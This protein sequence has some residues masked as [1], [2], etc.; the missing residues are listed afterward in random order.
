MLF[1]SQPLKQ[2]TPMKRSPWNRKLSE[3]KGPGLAQRIAQSLGN[4]IHHV[5]SEPTVFRSLAHRQNVAA[6]RCCFC[7]R[8]GLSQAAHVNLQLGG[9]GIGL[10]A[11]DALT[12]PACTT[13]FLR[14]G[15]HAKLD[16]GAK[17][18]KATSAAEQLAAVAQTREQLMKVGR[19]PDGAEADFQRFV[20][21]YLERAA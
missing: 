10:K 16:Q 6:L 13:I 2:K 17:F 9:K 15:C 14:V 8:T 5:R 7:G 3:P 11:S 21:A 18:D 12:F 4:A 19:W 20:V 1:R